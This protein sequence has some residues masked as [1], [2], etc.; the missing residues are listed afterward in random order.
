MK[1]DL[2][3]K[4]AQLYP[5]ERILD[6]GIK[7][8]MIAAC[9]KE[10]PAS[11]GEKVIEA[12]GCVV[13]PGFVDSHMHLDQTLLA[14][15]DDAT[16]VLSALIRSYHRNE[17]LYGGWSQEDIEEDIFSRAEPI[18]KKSI[19]NGTTVIKSYVMVNNV[20]G[21]AAFQAVKKLAEK[22]K[23]YVTIKNIVPLVAEYEDAWKAAAKAGEIDFIGGAP[24]IR[25]N[26]ITGLPEATLAYKG[27]TDRI[28]KM[29]A[30]YNLPIDIHCDESDTPNIDLFLYMAHKTMEYKMQGRVTCAHVTALSAKGM[31]EDHAAQAIAQCAKASMNIT[32]LTS[33][34]MYLMS[35]KRRGPTR[36]PQL[37]NAG[38]NV[39]I[40]SDNVRDFYRPFGNADLLEEALLTAQ[41]HKFGT[42]AKLNQTMRMI[43][44][45]PAANALVEDYGVTPGCRA[46]LVIL[47]A[48]NVPEA[49]L[50]QV[51]KKY[52]I[53]NGKITVENGQMI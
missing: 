25:N 35:G 36:V 52:V 51:E 12:Q 32:T 33:G 2:V 23:E 26:S 21:M 42:K 38:I 19:E 1:Y 30:E 44:F 47:D 8:G 6:I 5:L 3:I 45:Y 27:E 10:I 39:S 40:A 16:D 31:D 37:L 22:Y 17:E 53:K 14:D 11:D 9:E 18:I 46:D 29:A 15:E 49:I 28:F 4:G 20:W 34:D 13:T 50:S 24:N 43:T 7:D 41:V 48:P